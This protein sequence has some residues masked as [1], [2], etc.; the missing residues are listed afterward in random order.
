MSLKKRGALGEGIFSIYRFLLV[1]LVAFVILGLS[2]IFYAYTID[3]RDAE[4]SIMAWNLVNCISKLGL[5]DLDSIG[6]S[7]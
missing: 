7:S 3:I 1:A 5:T 4:S 2:S 6:Q